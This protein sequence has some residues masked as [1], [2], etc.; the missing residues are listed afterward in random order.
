MCTFG[1]LMDP[2]RPPFSTPQERE[3]PQKRGEYERF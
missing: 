1:S 2:E 3:K